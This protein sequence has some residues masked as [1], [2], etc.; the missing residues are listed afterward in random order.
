MTVRP[1]Q[2][3]G[4][5]AGTAVPVANGVGGA[6]RSN[7]FSWEEWFHHAAAPQRAEALRLAQQQGFLYPHQLAHLTNG[8]RPTALADDNSI[9]Q[10]LT[11]LLAGK[12]GPLPAFEPQTLSFFD[13]ELDE[14]QQQAVVR[15]LG[16]PDLFLLQG[17][18]GTGKSRVVAEVLLQAAARGWRV[19]FVAGQPA[20]VDVVLTRLLHRPEVFAL[21]YLEPD[22]ESHTLPPRVLALTPEEQGKAFLERMR[23]GARE[24]AHSAESCASRRREQEAVWPEL[25]TALQRSAELDGQLVSLRE[26]LAQIE[27]TIECE[28][29]TEPPVAPFAVQL[30]ELTRQ[31][32]QADQE[33]D[34]ALQTQRDALAKAEQEVSH[35]IE[36]MTAAEP[37]YR[38]KKDKQ[39]WTLSFWKHLL[40]GAILQKM[41][42]MQT[43]LDQARARQQEAAV[44]LAVVQDQLAASQQEFTQRRAALVQA[45]IQVRRGA[46]TLDVQRLTHERDE[47]SRRW[48]E[49]SRRVSE[50]PIDL[51][52]AAVESSRQAWQDRVAHEE[53]ACRFARQ[54][55]EFVDRTGSQLAARLPSLANV[56]AVPMSAL[57]RV[58]PDDEPFDLLVIEDADTLT[59]FDLLRAG[60]LARRCILVGH[61][62]TESVPA[63]Q[64]SER[65]VR[66][67]PPSA[68][69]LQSAVCWP[70]LWHALA[71][72]AGVAPY[73]WFHE[74]PRGDAG[75]A[76]APPRLICQLFPVAKEDRQ[77]LDRESLADAADVELRIMHRPKTTPCL[78]Q[79]AFPPEWSFARAFAFI[80]HEAQ[81]IPL[82][83]VCRTGWWQ[84]DALRCRWQT[85]PSS[86]RVH[87]WLDLETGVR[88]GAV[89]D[90]TGEPARM[91]CIEF[92]RAAG[93]DRARTEAWLERYRPSAEQ[94]RAVFLQIPHRFTPPL[95]RSLLSIVHCGDWLTAE[96]H[97]EHGGEPAFEFAAIPNCDAHDWPREGAGLELD[98]SAGRHA[99]RLPA[100]F[101]QGLPGRGYVNYLEAQ[102][103]VR[104][105]E[106]LV[107]E[108]DPAVEATA[109]GPIAILAL[110]ES[111]AELLRRLIGQSE[112]LRPRRETLLVALPSQMH[113]R[114][115]DTVLLSLTRS[116]THRCV[117]FGQDAQELPL[118]LTRARCRLVIFGD[119]GMLCKRSH[120]HGPLD[121]LDAAA[122]HQEWLR[123]SRLFACAQQQ[124][125]ALLLPCGLANGTSE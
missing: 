57:N 94:G 100:E 67:A 65:P 70:R 7:H 4:P 14:I 66:F 30:G 117:A 29:R 32:Q 11:R 8:N 39:F 89:G 63:P 59:E 55:I 68:V 76:G 3:S 49:L 10:T 82:R 6:E 88:L 113:Q 48:E 15:A 118:A 120:W 97:G 101:R 79:V 50:R 12:V 71:G 13:S 44:Q 20:S 27:T 108:G 23:G 53:E 114:E 43:H 84:D 47:L 93:W 105:L 17:F 104:R 103:V 85:A 73:S 33:S 64:A 41:Q 121:H 116:H 123:L 119:P 19:L 34:R 16:T 112:I 109:A 22:E 91:V 95:A 83:P 9:A 80:V 1:R 37:G 54:W 40:D 77:Y 107:Q 42:E 52:A 21:R 60:R 96:V 78:A 90:E 124:A 62:L 25:R 99:D 98:L 111:Q 110:Y 92:D 58:P 72:D 75:D 5:S 81:E 26:S 46:N 31:A 115:C 61:T 45:E 125:R 35:L 24:S 51:T 18:P 36:Q 106:S 122:S 56:L 38:A 69:P 74:P 87:T 28:A 86:T 2:A 102:A